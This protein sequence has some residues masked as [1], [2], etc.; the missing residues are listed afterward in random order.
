M[1]TTE[2]D[3]YGVLEFTENIYRIAKEFRS[4]KPFGGMFQ[5]DEFSSSKGRLAF[6]NVRGN[7]IYAEYF[8]DNDFHYKAEY[9]SYCPGSD[10]KIN[11]DTFRDSVL[12]PY[13]ELVFMTEEMYFQESCIHDVKVL[14]A[15]LFYGALL[16]HYK[17]NQRFF[18]DLVVYYKCV[19][20]LN[21]KYDN[22]SV[23]D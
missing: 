20:Y 2:Y 8:D 16:H 22:N 5:Y 4:P 10:L 18:L 12:V 21:A 17:Y 13:S 23:H 11:I 3:Y 15:M 9:I 6:T 1:I 7:Q 14:N 19:D